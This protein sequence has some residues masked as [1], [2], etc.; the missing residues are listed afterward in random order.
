MMKIFWPDNFAAILSQLEPTKVVWHKQ[1]ED[2]LFKMC[3]GI[4]AAT[5]VG[6]TG[7]TNMGY[8]LSKP[9]RLASEIFIFGMASPRL[10]NI[11]VFG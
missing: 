8:H 2:V 6:D 11:L 5:N 9:E 7:S 10:L 3:L 1:W 4:R